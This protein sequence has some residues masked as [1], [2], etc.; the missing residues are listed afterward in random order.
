VMMEDR[1]SKWKTT[2][3]HVHGRQLRFDGDLTRLDSTRL[4]S[5]LVESMDGQTS[6]ANDR[7]EGRMKESNQSDE[8]INRI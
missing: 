8:S 3:P 2:R 7:G 1:T 4:D 6:K 5:L